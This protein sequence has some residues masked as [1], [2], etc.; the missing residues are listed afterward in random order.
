M[1]ES[2]E[3]QLKSLQARIEALEGT[4]PAAAATDEKRAA[5]VK[6]AIKKHAELSKL[7]NKR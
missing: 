6:A 7:T 2:Q 3:N 1:E 5:E 4:K